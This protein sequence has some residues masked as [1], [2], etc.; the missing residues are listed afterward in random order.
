MNTEELHQHIAAREAEVAGYQVNI[1]NY[2]VIVGLIP[3]ELPAHLQMWAGLPIE[4]VIDQLPEADVQQVS[5]H[6]FRRSL[7]RR[8]IVERL[9]QRKAAF[10]LDALRQRLN[11]PPPEA[12]K[13]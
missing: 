8:L 9:E 1:D 13:G 7:Q 4:D 12:L 11:N 2:T 10:V 3:P 6:Q 5:D